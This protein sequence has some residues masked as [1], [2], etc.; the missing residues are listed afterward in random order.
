MSS[1]KR[2]AENITLDREKGDI[3]IDGQRLPWYVRENVGITGLRHDDLPSVEVSILCD[4]VHVIDSL[5]D[6]IKWIQTLGA[7][8]MQ[9]ALDD[10]LLA[11]INRR[12]ASGFLHF[13]TTAAFP[14]VRER[15]ATIHEGARA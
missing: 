1:E 6:D 11:E 3:W 14:N 5:D 12:A 15:L 2:I 4:N 7:Q 8:Q 10:F 13:V 9:S